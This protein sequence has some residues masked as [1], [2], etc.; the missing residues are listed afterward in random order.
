MARY[1][2]VYSRYGEIQTEE[3]DNFALAVAALQ[4]GAEF[5]E[6]FAL[7]IYDLQETTVYTPRRTECSQVHMADKIK[8]ALALSAVPSVSGE[9]DLFPSDGEEP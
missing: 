9:F 4:L 7:G 1:K 5:G 8:R 2:A 3:T 6:L